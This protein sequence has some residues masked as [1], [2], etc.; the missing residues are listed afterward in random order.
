MPDWIPVA[1]VADC[2]P[3]ASIERVADGRMVAI[4][5]IDGR[6]HAIDGL[7]PHQGG[8]RGTAGSSTSSVA[9]T[10][11]R[12][13][14]GRRFTKCGRKGDDCSFAWREETRRGGSRDR[15]SLL[16]Q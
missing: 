8:P 5:N 9:V 14:C 11:C 1:A 15:V 12:R 6:F 10:R 16:P 4:A 3:G 13:R 7:C 2:P